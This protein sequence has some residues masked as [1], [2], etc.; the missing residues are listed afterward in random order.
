[1]I[2]LAISQVAWTSPLAFL[3][4]VGVGLGLASRFRIIKRPD[5]D[6]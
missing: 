3:L 4:G 6:D 1:V 2:A 5:D